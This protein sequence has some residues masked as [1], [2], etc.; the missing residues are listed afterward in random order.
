MIPSPYNFEPALSDQEY[1]KLGI[2]ALR[3]SHIEHILGNCLKVILRLTDEEAVI[4]V[5]SLS[6]DQRAE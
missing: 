5:F 6:A 1:A 2:L 4:V 3:W